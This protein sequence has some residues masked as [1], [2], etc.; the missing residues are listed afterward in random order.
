MSADVHFSDMA[1]VTRDVRSSGYSGRDAER[2]QRPEMT[3][4]V[5]PGVLGKRACGVQAFVC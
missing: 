3:H 1:F 2:W 4:I 5:H